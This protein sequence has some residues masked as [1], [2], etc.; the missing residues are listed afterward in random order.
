MS[1][2]HGGELAGLAVIL[3]AT[4]VTIGAMSPS[5]HRYRYRADRPG[6]HATLKRRRVW[7]W[8]LT[9]TLVL[10]IAVGVMGAVFAREALSVRD[11]LLA[12]KSKLGQITG[13]ANQGDTEGLQTVAAEALELTTRANDTASGPLWN[14]AAS[15]PLVGQNISAVQAATSATHI[16]V[17]DAV[18]V[19]VRLLE[20]IDLDQLSVESG[21]INL[22]P[23][24]LAQADLPVINSAF[25]AAQAKIA[26][27]ELDGLHPVVADAVRELVDVVDE[28]APAV[29]LLEK[30]LPTIIAMLGGDGE[31]TYM[32]LFQNN[33]EIRATGGN[34]G[35]VSVMSVDNGAVEQRE[36]D[37]VLQA[38]WL[39]REARTPAAELPAETL[40]L[41]ERDFTLHS[42]NYTRT[43][44]FP[45]AAALFSGVWTKASG[46]QPDGIIALDPLVLAK[47]LEV[48]GPVTTEEGTE[49]NSENLVETLLFDTYERFGVQ[50]QLA[51]AYFADVADRTFQ[52]LTSGNWDPMKMLDA[53]K[54]GVDQGRIYGWF[55]REDEQALAVEL[56]IDGELSA[57]NAEA[58]EVGIYVND[59]SHGKLDYFY[60]QEIAVTCDAA[61]R[62]MTTTLTMHNNVPSPNLNGYTLGWRNSSLGLARTTMIH[63]VLFFAPP[64]AEI[65]GYEP[66]SDFAGWDRSGTEKGHA[67]QSVSLTIPMGESRTVSF[68][69]T[70]P[71]GE[72]GPLHVRFTPTLG[73]TPLTVA[74]TCGTF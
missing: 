38:H 65:I 5:T 8:V 56:G 1:C 4:P 48:T 21:G 29:A 37:T 12:A 51:D 33:A 59:A 55:A 25:A 10:L 7:P 43:P 2:A 62:T 13:L 35:A 73:D 50:G 53:L 14:V 69:S 42:A 46:S 64:G 54:W 15:I 47:I 41:Y 26:P 67:V 70:I 61:S 49:I 9:G 28:A 52:L 60:A 24:R 32:V 58:T 71:D 74:D 18:P 23:F 30:Y 27:I 31:R 36:D 34:P 57:D 17:R 40:E 72:V 44:D 68:T 19:G 11:D 66:A 16:L 20:T 39:F 63:D 45:T 22:E 3:I 6:Q